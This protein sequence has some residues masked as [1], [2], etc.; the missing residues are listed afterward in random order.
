[1]AD[2]GVT[3]VGRRGEARPGPV[4]R[5]PGGPL[6]AAMEREPVRT[7]GGR[8]QTG[9]HADDSDATGYHRSSRRNGSGY[10][11]ESPYGEEAPYGEESRHG[12][13][14][15][16]D[17]D[18]STGGR[19]PTA[20]RRFTPERA[21][22]PDDDGDDVILGAR[23]GTARSA[24]TGEP[25][26]FVRR[27]AV[28]L[29]VLSV[30][31]GVGVGAGVVWEKV[32]PSGHT[33]TAGAGG[34]DPTPTVVP[35][36]GATS[37][38]T[39]VA[40]QSAGQVAVPA[41]WVAFTDPIQ[42]VTYSHPPVWKQRRDNT[43]IFYGEP[44]TASDFG[45]AMIGATRL[46]GTDQTAALSQVQ[47]GEFAGV[48]GLSR[49]RSG[50]ATDSSGQPTQEIAGSYDREGQRVS[51][52]MRTVPGNGVVYVL[53]ARVSTDASASL[54]TLMGALRTSFSPAG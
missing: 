31:L 21:D 13:R 34:P 26:S 20:G 29:A 54:N 48:S 44:G 30:A 27:V 10:G 18:V 35:P 22:G 28:A 15:P 46:A 53:I 25:M 1:M 49:D 4:P 52:L 47:A 2:P 38:G 41:D 40:T 12:R 42:K 43:G 19:V 50:P 51:Y 32:R 8:D 14:R 16:A 5:R 23:G 9:P 7:G 24:S 17:R 37:A 11:Q 33:A 36:A 6:T 39:G 3:M 45:P